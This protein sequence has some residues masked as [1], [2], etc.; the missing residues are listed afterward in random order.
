M[1]ELPAKAMQ[2]LERIGAIADAAV[3]MVARYPEEYR[4]PILVSLLRAARVDE[5][6]TRDDSPRSSPGRG[7]SEMVD[8]ERDADA[9]GAAAVAAGVD[10]AGL[11]RIVQ[12]NEGGSV[13]L[14][15]RI[16]GGSMAERANRAAAVYCFIKEYGFGQRD[17][18][19]EELRR[20]CDEQKAYN[21]PNFTRNLRKCPWLLEIGD[22]GSRKRKYRLSAQG[23]EAAKAILRKL[24]E[25]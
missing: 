24:I 11:A 6:W 12:I 1:A 2:E 7:P 16:A 22:H 9:L 15:P 4:V 20:V 21:R 17:V 3:A 13:K 14:L 25:V 19:V 8:R 10:Q 18:G 23:E 5:P